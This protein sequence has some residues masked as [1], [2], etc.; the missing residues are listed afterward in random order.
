MA[1]CSKCGG[2]L[3][4]HAAFCPGCGQ[5]QGSS[6]AKSGSQSGLA[7]NVASTLCYSVGWITGLIFFLVDQRPSVRFHAAQSMVTFGGLH[8][9]RICLGFFLGV[10][11]MSSGMMDWARFSVGVAI[12]SLISLAG[13]LLW[14]V[15][16]VKAYQGERF[17]LPIAGDFAEQL[18]GK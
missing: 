11:M 7:E 4:D 5:S 14:I 10:G 12:L 15:C 6:P 13:M 2:Q 17:K 3:A 18:A 9:I 16:M 1:F 8:V